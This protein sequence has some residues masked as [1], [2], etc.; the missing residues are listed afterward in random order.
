MT[1]Y[2][3]LF[4]TFSLTSITFLFFLMNELK[5]YINSNS[6]SNSNSNNNSNN[7]SNSKKDDNEETQVQSK[8]DEIKYEDKYLS[9]VRNMNNNPL[10]EDK[11][12][13]ENKDKELEKILENYKNNIIIEKT[14]VGNVAMYYDSISETFTYYSDNTIPYRFLEVVARKYV[15]NYNCKQ[16]Y[17]DMEQEL[18]RKQLMD[19]ELKNK[20]LKEIELIN[21]NKSDKSVKFEN[22]IDNSNKIEKKSVF[23]KFKSYNKEAGS[24]RV[25]TAPPP[26]N[27]IPSNPVKTN[28][29]NSEECLLKDEANRYLCKGRF[30]NFNI[31]Q[32]VDKKKIDKK[33]ALNFADFKKKI[34]ESN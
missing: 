2:L 3:I 11:C 25:N 19:K 24:G 27:S 7:N 8:K 12:Q 32:K 13:D 16:L 17:I 10:L 5:S 34:I 30:S 28:S 14:P 1:F 18:E 6:N 20:K 9:R 33:Y 15:I 31:L 22:N 23:T 29:N 26:K 21:T 4:T